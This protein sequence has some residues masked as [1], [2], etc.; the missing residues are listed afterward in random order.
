M[1]FGILPRDDSWSVNRVS[2]KTVNQILKIKCYESSYTFAIHDSGWTLADG[3]LN[4]D[5]YYSDRLH[6][7][8]KGNLNLAESIFNSIEVSNDSNHNN[9]FSKS[10]KMAVSFKLNNKPFPRN[11]INRSFATATNTVFLAFHKIIFSL[12]LYLTLPTRLSLI[13]LVTFQSNTIGNLF[14][15]PFSRFKLFL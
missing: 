15:N 5:L 9:K 7:V 3:S 12:N 6:L 2:I 13:L 1:I 11:I 4:A 10:Y 14:P 8:E